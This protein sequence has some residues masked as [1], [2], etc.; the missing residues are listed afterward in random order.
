MKRL[1]TEGS[2]NYS[3]H[4]TNTLNATNNT[5]NL[6]NRN[7][8]TPSNKPYLEAIE[9]YKKLCLKTYATQNSSFLS[10]LKQESLNIYLDSYNLKDINAIN[11]IIGNYFYFKQIVLAPYDLNSKINNFSSL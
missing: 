3:I 2:N 11:K 6:L 1:T 8:R 9:D 10:T 4:S 7:P 5:L